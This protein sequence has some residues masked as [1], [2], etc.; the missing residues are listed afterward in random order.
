MA[1]E[2]P[3][4]VAQQQMEIGQCRMVRLG[5]AQQ[6]YPSLVALQFQLAMAKAK[7]DHDLFDTRDD[8]DAVVPVAVDLHQA[9][10]L[11]REATDVLL[12]EMNLGGIVTAAKV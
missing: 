5:I 10:R 1:L 8:P 4:S 6:V 3:N 2:L 11:A 9:A 7:Q 12:A